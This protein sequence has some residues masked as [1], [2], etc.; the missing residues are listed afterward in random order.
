[1]GSRVAVK[2]ELVHQVFEKRLKWFEYIYS[3]LH[4]AK[5]EDRRT[6]PRQDCKSKPDMIR[7]GWQNIQVKATLINSSREGVRVEMIGKHAPKP[8]T[9][10]KLNIKPNK[11][12]HAS[13]HLATKLLELSGGK[14][15]VVRTDT[16]KQRATSPKHYIALKKAR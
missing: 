12:D 8:H 10:V 15:E 9:R 6:Y 11:S 13:A 3:V 5:G 14:F 4:K 1:M 2:E 16:S 7:V